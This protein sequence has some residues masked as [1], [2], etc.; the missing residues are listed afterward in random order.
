MGPFDEDTYRDR[1]TNKYLDSLEDEGSL[2]SCCNAKFIE[3]TD[4]CS[5]CEEHAS[6]NDEY[7]EQ[8]R[9]DNG[10]AK[11]EEAREERMEREDK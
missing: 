8:V 11:F 10:D 1:Q 9:D 4:L 2:S 6:T 3:E 7:A 5:Q